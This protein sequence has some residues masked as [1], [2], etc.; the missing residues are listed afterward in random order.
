MRYHL[1]A[2][3]LLTTAVVGLAASA[4]ASAARA[5]RWEFTVQ[6]RYLDGQSFTSSGGSQVSTDSEVGWGFG[7]GYN[8]NENLALSFDI[9]WNSP[10]Y[11][12]T[13]VSADIPALAS[14]EVSGELSTSSYHLNLLYNFIAGPVTPFVSAGIG[15]TYVDSNIASGAPSTGCWYDP[16]YGY[17]CNTYQPTYSDSRFS[18]N[19]AV[20]VRWDLSREVFL[21]AGLGMQ[22]IDLANGG[23]QD[24]TVGRLELGFSY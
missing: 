7:F 12:A 4:T 16:W 3:T 17:I 2:V 22:W 24:F 13:L 9:G 23:N 21:R 5:E 19:A 11:D 15:S 8:F 6:M 14:R 20:G 1:L 10:S 18:Y